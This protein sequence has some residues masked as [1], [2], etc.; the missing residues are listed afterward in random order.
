MTDEAACCTR[1]NAPSVT[2]CRTRPPDFD[3]TCDEIRITWASVT[4]RNRY[5]VRWRMSSMRA[6]SSELQAPSW[7]LEAG[8][9][10]LV[11]RYLRQQVE[12]GQNLARAEDDGRQRILGHRGRQ[13][14][15]LARPLVEVFEERSA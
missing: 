5:P 7:K 1:A 11:D 13:P 12:V 15:L 10:K 9:W 8:T 14:G 4:A 3:C 2:D 6:S